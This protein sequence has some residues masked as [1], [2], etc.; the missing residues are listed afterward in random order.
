MTKYLKK[1]AGFSRALMK[2]LILCFAAL[3][4]IESAFAQSSPG[5]SYGQVPTPGQWNS[6]FSGK[7]DYPTPLSSGNVLTSNGSG[8]YS[9][10]PATN[11]TVTSVGVSGGTTGLTTSG[12]PVTS[13]GTVTISGTLGVANG[14][15]GNTTGTATV[16]A[17]LTGPITSVGNATSIASQ[18]GTGT[19]IVVDTSPT[20]ITPI[21]GA[22][23]ATSI[24]GNIFTTGTGTLTL[25]AGKTT[26][27][28][29]T[30]TFTTT[31][32]QTYTFPTTSATVARTDAAQN[33]SLMQPP[34]LSWRLKIVWI[35]CI[36]AF[37][38]RKLSNAPP[39][40]LMQ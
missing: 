19:K 33:F 37:P 15:T 28:N 38:M 18:T 1:Y 40:R 10:A 16:N 39:T 3:L 24:N 29:H 11:G 17:N 2:K 7:L 9:S 25:G 23:T 14:G 5:L 27:F 4:T 22:A 8:W 32:A 6:Y 31:D 21:L 30:S 13:S 26:T 35:Y 34:K 20:L 12:G 36:S